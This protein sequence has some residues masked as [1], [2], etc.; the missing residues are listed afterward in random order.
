[1]EERAKETISTVTQDTLGTTQQ[2]FVYNFVSNSFY[3]VNATLMA[4]GALTEIW[5]DKAEL[6][7]G[8]VDSSVVSSI[9]SALENQTPQGSKN[10][11][12][13]IVKLEE[14]YFGM[15]PNSGNSNG[16]VHFLITDIKDGWDSTKSSSFVAGFFLSN[17]QPD[18]N[19]HQYN[20]GSNKRDMLY[21]DSYPG[22]YYH[23]TR[24]P[25]EP[26]PTL[27]H[28]FQHLIQWHYDPGEVTF[29]N[30]GC[31]TNA[32][33]VC[34]YPMRSPALYFKDTNT[35]LFTW[36]STTDATVLADYS[37]ATIFMR[38]LFEQFGDTFAKDFV[39]N[40]AEGINGVNSTLAEVGSS[41]SFNQIFQNWVIA[42]TLNDT[43]VGHQYG[44]S[45]PIAAR[46]I[47]SKTFPDPNVCLAYDTT[48]SM[49]VNYLD[50]PTGDSLIISYDS[51]GLIVSAVES[52]TK[53]EV[54]SLSSAETFYEPQFGSTYKDV[55]LTLLNLASSGNGNISLTSSGKV[56]YVQSEI[57][58]DRGVADTLNGATFLGYP[59][60]SV[61]SGWA[62]QF[63]PASPDN[64]LVKAE[65]YAA[66]AQEFSGSTVPSSAPKQFLFHVWGDNSGV[67]GQ[68]LI[69][70][71]IVNVNRSSFD[72]SFIK[73]DL[74]PYAN[75]LTKLQGPVYIGFIED[76]SLSTSVGLNHQTSVNHTFGFSQSM[77]GGWAAM[78]GLSI[79][80]TDGVSQ[81]LKGWNLMMRAVLD[82]PTI[83][84]PP[85]KLTVG[86]TQGSIPSAQLNVICVGDSALRPTSICGT[87]AQSSGST[88][89]T[90]SQVSP[91][92][93]VSSNA[94]IQT[95]GT[96]GITLK[97]AKLLGANYADTAF[98]FSTTLAGGVSSAALASPDSLFSLTVPPIDGQFFATIYKGTID[99]VDSRANYVYSLG[100]KGKEFPTPVQI[101]LI[102][103]AFDTNQF[104][105]AVCQNSKWY[106]LPF[107]LQNGSLASSTTY[108]STFAV[109]PR[110][111]I[112]GPLPPPV[113]KVFALYQNYPNPFNPTTTISFQL[114]TSGF[115]SLKVFDVLG[116][117]VTTIANEPL[118]AGEH[119]YVWNASSYSSGVYFYQ[120]TA[121]SY[122]STKKMMLIK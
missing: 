30:E 59:D 53:S 67:P 60:G 103:V 61:G 29:L 64:Q 48:A 35:P 112:S 23:G 28:E 75:Q 66:F 47:P 18:P 52:G 93:F 19:T 34:G 83:S 1:M 6:A 120:L 116:R 3:S 26:L 9:E 107:S 42:N 105:P 86:I 50:F 82:Y 119:K 15:P 88:Q 87:L 100:P 72:Q 43:T 20:Y 71:F 12:E 46:P 36:H 38:Y 68:D 92:Q 85:P 94:A 118:D 39:Q 25:S 117:E 56:N 14:S 32:E 44:Y 21:I 5:V 41:L 31:S 115:V 76:D 73:I 65:I 10:P 74:T 79:N 37:R 111:I 13:G 51:D 27:A 97:A 102:A 113:P 4:K 108:F 109:V 11:N 104:A 55:T 69:A 54:K 89:L 91:N 8:H 57:S 98:V 40:P 7:N 33:V 2:F 121:G 96:V 101:L 24:N 84:S 99:T 45:Y 78:S 63:M 17:D 16:Y 122:I 90:F 106:R 77:F 114:P 58:Y 81:Q 70:P 95:G 110:E 62:V 80:T 22:I 49:A